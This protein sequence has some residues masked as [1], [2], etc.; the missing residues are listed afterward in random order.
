MGTAC[1]GPAT[2]TTQR[3]IDWGEF[4]DTFEMRLPAETLTAPVSQEVTALEEAVS[5]EDFNA[6]LSPLERFGADV[7]RNRIGRKLTQG[8]L[9]TAVG[10]SVSYVSQVESGKILPS[11]QFAKGCDLVFGTHGIFA[12]MLRQIEDG[13][14]P[15]NFVPYVQLE[16]KASLVQGYSATTIMG[17]LQTDE[18]AR[19]IFR[20][21]HPHERDEVV[22][23]KVTARIK[24]RGVLERDNPPKVWAVLHEASL[25]THVGGQTVMA[26][27]L[28]HIVKWAERPGIDVQVIDFEAG[29]NGVHSSPFT[30][31]SFPDSPSVVYTGDLR[32]GRLHRDP[33]AVAAALETYDRLRAHALSP[34]KSLAFMKTVCKEYTP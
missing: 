1:T 13:D 21:G 8:R 23:G 11:E 6:D 20:A 16:Q 14:H 3:A 18:Y 7:K 9:G 22:Q 5:S 26:R 19:A 29:A 17:L 15:S 28:E 4:N 25:R 33:R 27:Q 12:G 10:Y 30:L 24:R 34:D 2:R 32:G 31:L